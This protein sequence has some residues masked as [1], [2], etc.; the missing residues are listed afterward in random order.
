MEQDLYNRLPCGG[1]LWNYKYNNKD[2][3]IQKYYEN[4]NRERIIYN[5]SNNKLPIKKE[6]RKQKLMNL[7]IHKIDELA[8][9]YTP[10]MFEQ[11]EKIFKEKI[12]DFITNNN[13]FGPKKKRILLS[14]ITQNNYSNIDEMGKYVSE[15]LSWF[16]EMSFKYIPEHTSVEKRDENIMYITANRNMFIMY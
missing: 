6:L 16:L 13:E 4:D 7:I 14:W 2:N 11:A 1:G 8:S 3:F 5:A 15:F 10:I 12:T 9:L